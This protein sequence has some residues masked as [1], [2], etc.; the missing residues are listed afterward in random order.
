MDNYNDMSVSDL[1]VLSRERDDSA[2]SELVSRYTP[3][4]SKVIGGFSDF[5]F[6]LFF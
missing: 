2:F 6:L 3:M 4:I 5:S 1:I